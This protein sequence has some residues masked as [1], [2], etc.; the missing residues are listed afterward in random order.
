MYR[1]L[2]ATLILSAPLAATLPAMAQ[3]RLKAVTSFTILADMAQNVAGDAAGA[4][5]TAG[6]DA[7]GDTDVDGVCDNF[8]LCPGE[9]DTTADADDDGVCQAKEDL[10]R[11]PWS[12]TKVAGSYTEPGPIIATD[13]DHDGDLDWVSAHLNWRRL[14][15]WENDGG[16]SEA[17]GATLEGKPRWFD[18]FNLDGDEERDVVYGGAADNWLSTLTKQSDFKLGSESFIDHAVHTHVL[19]MN[20]DDDELEDVVAYN[21]E[22]DEFVLLMNGAGGLG[23]PSPFASVVDGQFRGPGMAALDVNGD[24]RDDLVVSTSEGLGW[25][26]NSGSG[27][28]AYTSISV[29]GIG[30]MLDVVDVDGDGMLDI[31]GISSGAIR[32]Y[33]NTGNG[34]FGLQLLFFS[35]AWDFIRVVDIDQ[36]G[37]SDFVLSKASPATLAWSEQ[38]NTGAFLPPTTIGTATNGGFIDVGDFDGDDDVDVVWGDLDLPG[39]IW[40]ENPRY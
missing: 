40:F 11:A 7:S 21:A 12:F 38:T 1:R 24:R 23:A 16:I 22:D 30:S 39:Y 25:F 35:Q 32:W 13:M 36:D 34:V 18:V 14:V 19:A 17:Y 9:S 4:V 10:L 28:G 29:S 6:D 26:E 37:R 27:F 15:L 33:K 20:V 8:D 2:F 3:D 31:V 5:V